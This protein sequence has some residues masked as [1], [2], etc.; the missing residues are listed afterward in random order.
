MGVLEQFQD[1]CT[2]FHYTWFRYVLHSLVLL[3]PPPQAL[4]LSVQLVLFDLL[5]KEDNSLLVQSVL[6]LKCL[7][8]AIPDAVDLLKVVDLG[9]TVVNET[10]LVC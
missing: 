4:I 10:L 8:N 1:I 6:V 3:N 5:L 7:H 9:V 2:L